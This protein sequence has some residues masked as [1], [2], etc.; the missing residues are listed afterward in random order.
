[1]GKNINTD[2]ERLKVALKIVLEDLQ[3]H[4]D[5]QNNEKNWNAVISKVNNILSFVSQLD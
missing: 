3:K 1:M 2:H 4:N 5:W